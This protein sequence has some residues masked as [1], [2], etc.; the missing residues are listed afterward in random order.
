MGVG[1]GETPWQPRCEEHDLKVPDTPG[2]G[3]VLIEGYRNGKKGVL[4]K[5]HGDP[6]GH[7]NGNCASGGLQA[8]GDMGGIPAWILTDW[9]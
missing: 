8:Q 5:H 9:I 4:P 2:S 1:V 6:R 3:L 7:C